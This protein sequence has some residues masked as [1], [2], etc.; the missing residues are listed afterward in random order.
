[1]QEFVAVI[2]Q[3]ILQV[4]CKNLVNRLTPEIKFAITCA[5][6]EIV[7]KKKIVTVTS[8]L[9]PPELFLV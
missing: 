4:S 8:R 7:Y 3:R 6:S 9:E 1:M 5:Y 2:F